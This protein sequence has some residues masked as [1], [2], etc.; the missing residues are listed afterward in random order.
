MRPIPQPEGRSSLILRAWNRTDS[1]YTPT[2]EG[3]QTLSFL[4]ENRSFRIFRKFFEE[5]RN[6]FPGAT[7]TVFVSG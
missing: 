3:P 2:R 7:T 1:L 4:N 6:T 5:S